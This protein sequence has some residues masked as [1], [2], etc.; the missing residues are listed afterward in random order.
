MTMCRAMWLTWRRT[1]TLIALS[2]SMV[3]ASSILLSGCSLLLPY[4]APVDINALR[5]QHHYVSALHALDKQ[6]ATTPAYLD[7]HQ[8]LLDEA[9]QYQSQ[10]LQSLRKLMEQQDFAEAQKQLREAIGEL[11]PNAEL[12]AF[13]TELMQARNFYVKDKLDELYQLRGEH[14]LKEQPIYQ[15]LQGITGDNELQVAVERY[16]ADADYFAKL[17]GAAGAEA[18]QREDYSAAQKYLATAN[19]LRPSVELMAAIDA[20]K[21]AISARRERDLQNRNNE[22]E[23]H[24]R[25]L[26]TTLQ[27]L[28]AKNDFQNART[29]LNNLRDIGLHVGD[30]E[31]YK[32]RLND[33]LATYVAEQTDAG[34]KL[35]AESHIEV[36]LEHWRDAY[37][38]LPTPELKERI[39]KAEKFMRRY[40]NLKQQ[41]TR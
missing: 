30:V 41:P 7:Q 39:E 18:M 31:Q 19:Q 4:S 29:Q 28:M 32:R 11:P 33:A 21:R 38:L 24:Y 10:L 36:A 35:Y 16:Q 26:E 25:K 34:N 13:T 1:F 6:R 2:M 27:Q 40:E 23:Q 22:R 15:S 5:A 17:L 9:T 14:L 3:I 20:A 37:A 12:T 8:A